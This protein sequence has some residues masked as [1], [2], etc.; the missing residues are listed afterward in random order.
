MISFKNVCS[1]DVH[2]EFETERQYIDIFLETIKGYRPNFEVAIE[3]KYFKKSDKRNLQLALDEAEV[4][5]K[6]YMATNKFNL[7]PNVKAFVVVAHGQKLVWRAVA[8]N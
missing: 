5:I 6:N 4:Q 7:R 1:V 2:S 8:T 3:L